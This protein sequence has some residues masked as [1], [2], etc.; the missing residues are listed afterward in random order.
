MFAHLP[1]IFRQLLFQRVK[2][3]DARGQMFAHLPQ[4]I[5]QL[6]FQS[7]KACGSIFKWN[8]RC[9]AQRKKLKGVFINIVLLPQSKKI[10]KKYI[11]FP[12]FMILKIYLLYWCVRLVFGAY[13]HTDI[14]A[15]WIINWWF[16]SKQSWVVS[17]LLLLPVA[18][19]TQIY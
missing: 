11:G 15:S 19:L 12:T 2:D 1:E 3:G 10:I 8:F 14:E 9:A 13:V 5:R 7:V 16:S 4:I 6:L 17:Y 18:N